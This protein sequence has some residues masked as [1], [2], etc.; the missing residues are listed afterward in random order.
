[1]GEVIWMQVR[2]VLC[3]AVVSTMHFVYDVY[4]QYSAVQGSMYMLVALSVH[5]VDAVV[6]RFAFGAWQWVLVD[7]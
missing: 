6:C 3:C 4:V 5:A 7:S 2:I 1:M